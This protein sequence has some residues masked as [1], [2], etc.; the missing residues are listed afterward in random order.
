MRLFS[1]LVISAAVL[2]HCPLAFK[3]PTKQSG[4]AYIVA[5]RSCGSAADGAAIICGRNCL[6]CGRRSLHRVSAYIYAFVPFALSKL[7]C[8]FAVVTIRFVGAGFP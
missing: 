4:L 7:S 1:S 3:T 2:G 6:W 5:E 8:S